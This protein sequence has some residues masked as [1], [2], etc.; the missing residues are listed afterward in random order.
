[1]GVITASH[2]ARL[3]RMEVKCTARDNLEES[4]HRDIETEIIHIAQY[5]RML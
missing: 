4:M 2:E 3:P 5:A 1:M